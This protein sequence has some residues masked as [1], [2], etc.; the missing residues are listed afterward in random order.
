MRKIG[1]LIFHR[2][3]VRLF[4]YSRWLTNACWNENQNQMNKTRLNWAHEHF[5]QRPLNCL[6]FLSI[7][8]PMLVSIKYCPLC[9]EYPSVSFHLSWFPPLLI[10][11]CCFCT[12]FFW[13]STIPLASDCPCGPGWLLPKLF[14]LYLFPHC[15]WPICWYPTGLGSLP[16]HKGL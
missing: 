15:L 4:A 7:F 11:P 1:R 8:F 10:T 16:P 5:V 3:Q 2:S 6:I 12:C 14:K 13:A 9:L